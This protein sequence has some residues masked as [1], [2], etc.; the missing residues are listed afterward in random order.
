MNERDILRTEL[1]WGAI[2]AGAVALIIAVIVVSS[3]AMLLH[4][5][6]NVETIDPAT[7]H[8]EGEFVESNLGTIQ[9]GPD[10][11]V[12]ARIVA[13]QFTFVPRCLAVPAD[14]PVDACASRARIVIHG[15]LDRR[16]ERQHDGHPR[17][18]LAGQARCS[19]S[20]AITSCRATNTAASATAR[21]GAS[22]ASCR[23]RMEARRARA[24]SAVKSRAEPSGDRSHLGRVRRVRR[25]GRHGRCAD[26]RREARWTAAG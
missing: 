2:V 20:P 11:S 1:R 3:A 25:G 10:G 23:R 6:S 18:R 5:P 8:H 12:I 17:L 26:A 22:S 4:P 24:G 9:N 21:C 14:R 16:H 19:R 13:T 15:L 7:I